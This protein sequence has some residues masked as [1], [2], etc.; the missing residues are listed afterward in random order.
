MHQLVLETVNLANTF[1]IT[2]RY[3]FIVTIGIDGQLP[4]LPNDHCS[5]SSVYKLTIDL[6]VHSSQV[7]YTQLILFTFDETRIGNH[8]TGDWVTWNTFEVSQAVISELSGPIN[9]R[10]Q[11]H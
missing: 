1:D 9:I 2:V 7:I 3:V 11:P 8:I 4:M 5:G 10:R 6:N